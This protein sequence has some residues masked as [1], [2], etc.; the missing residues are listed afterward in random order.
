MQSEAVLIEVCAQNAGGDH[1]MKSSTVARYA[2]SKSVRKRQTTQQK[3][4]VISPKKEAETY[5]HVKKNGSS[6]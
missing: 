4:T 6:L 1:F 5:K 2:L 3:K